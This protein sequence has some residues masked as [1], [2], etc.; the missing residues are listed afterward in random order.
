MENVDKIFAELKSKG[1]RVLMPPTEREGEG[2]RLA[3]FLDPKAFAGEDFFL[4]ETEALVRRVKRCP[5]LPGV[6]EIL[7]P[8]EPE[9]RAYAERTRSGIT[10]EEATWACLTEIAQERGVATPGVTF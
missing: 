9:E 3:V 8:G 6:D 5:T 1:V 10:I 4:E 7:V 2:I